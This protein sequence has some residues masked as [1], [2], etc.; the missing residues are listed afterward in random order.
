MDVTGVIDRKIA[1]LLAHTS[2]M[3]EWPEGNVGVA[4]AVREWLHKAGE[5]HGFDYAETFRVLKLRR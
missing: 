3:G 1:A 2:Q 5:A 4:A